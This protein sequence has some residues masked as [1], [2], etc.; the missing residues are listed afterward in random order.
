[1][2]AYEYDLMNQV[3]YK[4]IKGGESG[5]ALKR[6]ML[7]R[8]EVD[9]DEIQRAFKGKYGIQLTEAICGRTFCDDYTDF[10]VALATKK[11]Q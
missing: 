2:H 10:F 7:S 8:A 6:V 1:M 3:L 9:L 4:S 11:A 5:E